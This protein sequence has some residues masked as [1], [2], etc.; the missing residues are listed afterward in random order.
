M[1]KGFICEHCKKQVPVNRTIGTWHRNQCPYCL[2]SK[3]V[4]IFKGDRK[5]ACLGAME[6][7]GLT[8][9]QE[10]TDKYGKPRQ[11]E[12]MIIHRC[13]E[14]NKFSIN[15]IAADDDPKVI[16]ELFEKSLSLPQETKDDLENENLK[17]LDEKDREE[18]RVQL[19][20]RITS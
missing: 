9:K 4:D 6:P 11:G 1:E 19:F 17:L 2:W 13:L 20:G 14:C 18:I 3:D 7:I 10:G 12:L 8:F 16:L 5:S 15:R